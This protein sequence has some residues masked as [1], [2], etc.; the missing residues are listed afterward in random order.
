METFQGYLRGDGQVGIRN[1]VVVMAATNYVNSLVGEIANKVPGVIPLRHTDGGGDPRKS[2][3]Y[4]DLLINLAHNPN[5]YA[6][7]LVGLGGNEPHSKTIAEGIASNGM[8]FFYADLEKEG[9]R[10]SLIKHA[11]GA[12]VS[13]LKDSRRQKRQEIPMSRIVLGTECGGS[14]ALSGI[15]ANPAIGYVSD[16]LVSLG[17]TSVLTETAEMIGTE[18]ILSS[19]TEDPK[20][21]AEI[22]KRIT[23]MRDMV[24]SV[25]GLDAASV[26]PGNMKGGLTTIQEKSLGCINKAGLSRISGLYDYGELV[27][28]RKGLLIM[29]GTNHDAESLTGL[30][31]SGIQ[32]TMF[33]SGRGSPL[34]F[35]SCPVI[36]ICSNPESYRHMPG[37]IDINAGK[38][39]TDGMSLQ[40]LGDE[41][42]EYFKAV[43]NGKQTVAEAN[44]YWGP[45]GIAKKLIADK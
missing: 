1:N 33:S 11:T 25:S 42:I 39:V 31:A 9:S 32:V 28:E 8:P 43:L 20:L 2:P 10:D 18:E 5:H 35:P 37:D 30:F 40:Q 17:G 12:A 16:W 27:G 23:D 3:F 24:I 44:R 38:I 26:S 34:A 15:T 41:C 36:K 19:R 6:V 29:D 22:H 21:A 14:D 45:I 13:F 7:I 4:N